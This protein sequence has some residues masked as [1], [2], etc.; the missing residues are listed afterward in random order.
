MKWLGGILLLLV[1][2]NGQ[3]SDNQTG[4]A[5]SGLLAEKVAERQNFNLGG[6]DSCFTPDNE[7]GRC[8]PLTDCPV[9]LPLARQLQQQDI[10]NFFT[11]R[12][13]RLLFR[14]VHVCCP[15]NPNP[16]MPGGSI[17]ISPRPT[18]SIN[19][20][21]CGIPSGDRVIGGTEVEYPGKWPWLAALGIRRFGRFIPTCGGTLITSRHVLSAAHCFKDKQ[22]SPNIVR[23]GEHSLSKTDE[24]ANPQDFSI[25]EQ[26][27]NGYNS[28]TQENDI[29]ILVLDREVQFS[30]LV[31]PACLP[32]NEVNNEFEGQSLTVVGWGTTSTS[33]RTDVPMEADVSIVPRSQCVTAYLNTQ[34]R[35]VVDERQLCAGEGTRD[36]CSG[37]SGGPLNHR[38]PGGRYTV[39]GIVSFGVGCARAEFPGVYTRVSSF[40]DWIEKNVQ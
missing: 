9:Y 7:P 39:A 26:R 4:E 14:T 20:N 17:Q 16:L 15:T 19:I 13:C 23:L 10:I 35:P 28:K 32:Y 18:T 36:S 31:V 1:T 30:S 34:D 5:L 21:D 27:N 25:V 6:D 12:I 29:I 38:G 11:S 24:G 33:P 8:G 22:Q 40:L 3:L 37:D 2:V